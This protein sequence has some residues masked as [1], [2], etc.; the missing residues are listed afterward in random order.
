MKRFVRP[1]PRNRYMSVRMGSLN[2]ADIREV[3]PGDFIKHR[4][5]IGVHLS[6][7]QAPELSP[8]IIKQDTFFVP[9]RINWSFWDNYVS[10]KLLSDTTVGPFEENQL[11][12]PQLLVCMGTGHGV[13]GTSGSNHMD[14]VRGVFDLLEQLGMKLSYTDK[15]PPSG[16]LVGTGSVMMFNAFPLMSYWNIWHTF[17]RD[18]YLQNDE[19]QCDTI[20]TVGSTLISQQ[21]MPL[22]GDPWADESPVLDSENTSGSWQLPMSAHGFSGPGAVLPGYIL[23]VYEPL[24]TP[25]KATRGIFTFAKRQPGMAVGIQHDSVK[26][27]F[28]GVAAVLFA[29]YGKSDGSE[30]D[31]SIGMCAPVCMPKDYIFSLR[32]S[33]IY[34]TDVVVPGTVR[35]LRK[36]FQVLG[37]KEKVIRFDNRIK[38]WLWNFFHVNTSDKRLDSPYWLGGTQSIINTQEVLGTVNNTDTVLGQLGGFGIGACQGRYRK[39]RSEEHGFLITC[40]YI[41]ALPVYGDGIDRY[42]FRGRLNPRTR[43]PMEDGSLDWP[44]PD[45]ARIGQQSVHIGEIQAIGNRLDVNDG[46]LQYEN[47]LGYGDRFSELSFGRSDVCGDFRTILKFWHTGLFF[48]DTVSPNLSSGTGELPRPTGISGDFISYYERNRNNSRIVGLPNISTV[49]SQRLFDSG[50]TADQFWCVVS[51]DYHVSSRLPS[52]PHPGY[53]DHTS[54]VV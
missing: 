19:F 34:N 35:D 47:I 6:P 28:P 8:L 36:A 27:L 30:P 51:S 14:N 9:N 48:S 26:S 39:M 45:F 15:N 23:N 33:P 41:A 3:S 32:Q 31:Y 49:L 1:V 43:L 46:S 21:S 13:R 16:A 18:S 20:R 4:V 29:D 44:I 25:H 52:H 12:P 22:D 42:W 24:L 2:V 17:Y 53:A 37:Y 54:K 11:L 5:R 38:A 40:F 50:N 7:M 10:Q